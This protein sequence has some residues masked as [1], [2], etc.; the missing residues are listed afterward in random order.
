[1]KRLTD[2]LGIIQLSRDQL[3]N[4]LQSAREEVAAVS[5]ERDLA[6]SKC[7]SSAVGIETQIA[8]TNQIEEL[9]RNLLSSNTLKEEM[10]KALLA[11][12]KHLSDMQLELLRVTQVHEQLQQSSAGTITHIRDKS[13]S[14]AVDQAGSTLPLTDNTVNL[15]EDGL[16]EK[17]VMLLM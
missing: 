4:D 9:Q 2:E 15:L 11:S 16:K 12:E 5:R 6:E 1:M 14:D 8:Q 7:S 17:E 3:E 13:E 10:A